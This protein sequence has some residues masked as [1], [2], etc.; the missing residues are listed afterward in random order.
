MFVIIQNYLGGILETTKESR[1]SPRKLI[2][3]KF[4]QLTLTEKAHICCCQEEKI[5]MLICG[6]SETSVKR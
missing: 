6:T 2:M 4:T 5:V 1:P 3:D